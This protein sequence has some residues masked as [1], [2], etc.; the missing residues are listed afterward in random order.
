MD[1]EPPALFPQRRC[2]ASR[3][4]FH[5]SVHLLS[6]CIL[7]S[8]TL[9]SASSLHQHGLVSLLQLPLEKKTLS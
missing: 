4:S 5:A 2:S 8:V 3:I 6:G 9:S 1:Q 7:L